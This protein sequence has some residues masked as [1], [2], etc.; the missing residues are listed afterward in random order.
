MRLFIAIQLDESV[1]N[2]LIATQ[3]EFRQR[4]FKGRYTDIINMHLTL[5]FIGEFNDLDVI[6]DAMEQV[7]FEPFTLTLGGYIGNFGELFWAGVE[8]NPQ[9]EKI[10]KQL[11]HLLAENQIP[12]DRKS[13]SPHITLLRNAKGNR[14][15]SDIEVGKAT[16]TVRGISL[17]R[18]DFGKHGVFYTEIGRI[19]SN[20]P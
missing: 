5:A 18:S 1:K 4:G 19:E 6:L 3:N 8:K 16:M 15:F 11:R 7:R 12:F 9:L 2:A 14:G 20:E 13:F 17:M 10:V